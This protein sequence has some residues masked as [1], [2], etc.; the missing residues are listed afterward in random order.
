MSFD[1]FLLQRGVDCQS[2]L[3]E[4]EQALLSQYEADC[5]RTAPP[6][7]VLVTP[8]DCQWPSRGYWLPVVGQ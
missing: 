2:L 7:S 1:D 6:S 5:Q 8:V 4:L 3:P